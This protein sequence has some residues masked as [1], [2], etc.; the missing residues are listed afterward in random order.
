MRFLTRSLVALFLAAVALGLLGLAAGMVQSTLAERA[1]REQVQR[2]MR[3]RVFSARVLTVTPGDVAPVLSAFG[4]IAARRTLDLRA[5]ATGRILEIA[6]EFEN[7]APVREG[8]VLVRLDPADAIAARDLARADVARAEADLGD[9]ARALDLARLDR[10]E[11]EAQSELRRRAFERRQE[12][13]ERGAAT[14]ASVEESE[15]AFAASRAAVIARMQAEAQA[16]ARHAQAATTLERQ[17]INLSEA[18]RRLRET[19]LRATFGGVLSDTAAVVGGH[20]GMNERLARVIDPDSLEV[21]FRLS[22][23]QYLR[24][25]DASGTLVQVPAEVAL[26]LG[27]LEVTSPAQVTRAS[28]SVG[29]GQSGRLV[30]ARVDSP[31]GFRPGDFVT[32][33]ITEPVL[34]GVA[35]IPTAAVDAAGVVLVV[36]DEERL[37]EVQVDVLR[38][39]GDWVLI[40]PRNWPGARSWQPATLCWGRVSGSVRSARARRPS[41]LRPKRRK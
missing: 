19:E 12:L 13:T 31:R 15:L 17:R 7:G 38:R 34:S 18:E 21:A 23:A 39:M 36:G 22:T 29:E 2:P 1:S 6:D 41:P 24:L 14:A 32:V 40:R 28:P 20:V 8:Q 3:E 37:E 25:L 4:E 30:Y 27:E 11:S 9:A 10:A 26:E 35:Q 33:R 16:E 5:P